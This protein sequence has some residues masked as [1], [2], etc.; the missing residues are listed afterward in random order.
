MRRFAERYP[1]P[2]VSKSR[3]DNLNPFALWGCRVSLTVLG[4]P[5]SLRDKVKGILANA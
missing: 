2:R 3:H 4:H 1:A 5:F